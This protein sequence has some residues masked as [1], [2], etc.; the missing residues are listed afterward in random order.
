MR[1]FWR[2]DVQHHDFDF[3][4]GRNDLAGMDV[5]LGPGHLGDVHQTFDPRLQLHEGA[6]VGDVGDAAL[7]LGADRV[8]GFHAFPRIGLQLLH[9]EADALGFL[10]EADDLD[11]D[12]LADLEGFGRVVDAAPR[13][14]GDVQQAVDAA[15][16]DER[17]V[18][19][20][21]L[22]DAVEDLAFLEVGDQ[23]GA[24]CSA[25]LSSS[26]A[27]RDTTMLPRGGPS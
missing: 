22:D 24:G 13:D 27:R 3:L 26:T 7:E 19:G 8:L 10:V 20:D 1:R 5:L 21:V 11:R 23:F 16:I 4:R 17:A 15:E 14:V 18:I 2:I 12:G 25:R 6:V 9:A